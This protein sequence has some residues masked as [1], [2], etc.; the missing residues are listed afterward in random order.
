MK[1]FWALGWQAILRRPGKVAY[2]E[3]FEAVASYV[4]RLGS[5]LAFKSHSAPRPPQTP[6]AS[7]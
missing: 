6:A 7:F 2:S 5:P 4:R 1:R 3:R